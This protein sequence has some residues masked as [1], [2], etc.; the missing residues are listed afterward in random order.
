MIFQNPSIALIGMP[1]VGKSTVGV[2]LAKQLGYD[3]LDTDILIQTKENM[4][5]PQ[6]IKKKGLKGF[7]DIEAAHVLGLGTELQV[8]STGG[9]VIYRERAM[10]HL[11]KIATVVYL[12]AD[13][14]TLLT[15]LSDIEGRGVAI[16]PSSSIDTLYKERTS[17]YD[18]FCDIKIVCGENQPGQVAADVAATLAG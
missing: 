18:K 11:K 8:I 14:P 2:L 6:I 9:S 4:T 10:R 5:L 17:L 13:L 12:Y 3:F 7:L 1:A 16:D 15:R